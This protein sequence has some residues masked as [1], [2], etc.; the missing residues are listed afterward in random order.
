MHFDCSN[1][2]SAKT[3]VSYVWRTVVLKIRC[4]RS[5][6]VK[7]FNVTFSNILA[8]SRRSVLLVEETGENHR[9]VAS[10]S[11]TL[12]QNAV[13]STPRYERESNAQL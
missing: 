4:Y 12:S 2:A 9:P 5:Y 8:L 3:N 1:R 6:G 13:W 10:H 7:V 11:Q